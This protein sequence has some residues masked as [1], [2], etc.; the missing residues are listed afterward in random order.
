[1]TTTALLCSAVAEVVSILSSLFRRWSD[2]GAD[3]GCVKTR[4]K[5]NFEGHST[6]PDAP[7]ASP[8]AIGDV[9]SQAS[10]RSRALSHSLDPERTL[11]VVTTVATSD[12]TFP[13]GSGQP[14]SVRRL[15]Y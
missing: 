6:L 4:K 8:A 7:I 5:L 12:L 14:V 1:M 11:D 2:A 15:Q 10:W 3:R 13:S 9:K